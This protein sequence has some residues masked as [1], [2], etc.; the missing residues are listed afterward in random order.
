MLDNG[1]TAIGFGSYLGLVYRAAKFP[2]LTT[3]AD[4]NC[5]KA[6]VLLIVTNMLCLPAAILSLVVQSSL[7]E[8]SLLTAMLLGRFIPIFYASFVLVALSE[9]VAIKMKLF[10][11]KLS[12]YKRMHVDKDLEVKAATSHEDDLE[13]FNLFP[14]MTLVRVGTSKKR[15]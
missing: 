12:M 9:Y 10:D 2:N 15:F 1:Q 6:I 13:S 8:M 7:S 3:V 11:L 14:D 5:K 4:Q